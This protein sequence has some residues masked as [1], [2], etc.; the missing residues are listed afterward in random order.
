V[1]IT[2][3]DARAILAILGEGPAPDPEDDPDYGESEVR[4][5]A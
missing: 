4:E 3:Y 5:S 1:T 2:S